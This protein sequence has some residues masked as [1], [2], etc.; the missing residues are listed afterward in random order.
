[1]IKESSRFHG[2]V[3]EKIEQTQIRI[4]FGSK[5]GSYLDIKTYLLLKC[6]K[7][8]IKFF[9]KLLK[10]FKQNNKYFRFNV[11][12]FPQ[13]SVKTKDLLQFRCINS[14]VDGSGSAILEN[15]RQN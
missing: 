7:P 6:Q 3:E 2:Y 1:M 8:Y 15:L 9:L 14:D 11:S 10:S 13:L 12:N 5:S 4:R